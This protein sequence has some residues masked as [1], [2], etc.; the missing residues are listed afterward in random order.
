MQVIDSKPPSFSLPLLILLILFLLLRLKLDRQTVHTMPLIR[1]S[2][3]LSFEHMSQMPSTVTT[4][5]LCPHHS[6][7]RI[8]VSVHCPRNLSIKRRP[9]TATTKLTVRSEQGSTTSTA[10][11]NSFF[12]KFVVLSSAGWFSALLS[13]DVEFLSSEELLP[14]LLIRRRRVRDG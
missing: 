10:F 12:I 7:C 2:K 5:N 11:I 1:C 6:I 13:Q 14:F 9:S 8:S 3:L 4:C